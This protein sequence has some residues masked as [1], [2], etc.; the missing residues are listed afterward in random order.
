MGF[1]DDGLLR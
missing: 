1:S